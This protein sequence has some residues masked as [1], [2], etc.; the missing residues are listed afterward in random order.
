MTSTSIVPADKITEPTPPA[1]T[2]TSMLQHKIA[3]QTWNIASEDVITNTQHLDPEARLL[4][5]WIFEWAHLSRP[6]KTLQ[7]AAEAAG[8]DRTT[9]YRVLSG[10]YKRDGKQ[11]IIPA[12]LL[13]GLANLKRLEDAR[14][15]QGKVPFVLTKTAERIWG[16]ADRCL[17]RNCIGF[18]WG[19]SQYGKTTALKEYQRTHNHGQTK[20]IC[21]APG[22][23]A[24]DLLRAIAT[25]CGI[26]PKASIAELRDRIIAALDHNHLVIVDEVHQAAATYKRQSKITSIELLRWIHDQT[27]CGMLLCGTN[28]WRD[29][30]ERDS[31]SKLL[32]QVARRGALKLQ[33][34]TKIPQADLNQIFAAFELPAPEGEAAKIMRQIADRMGL[35]VVT[36]TLAFG[37]RQGKKQGREFPT[38]DDVVEAAEILESLE[39]GNI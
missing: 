2:G 34:P 11:D 13:S 26:S 16:I 20:Y 22:G 24:Q 18:L 33:L 17:E 21:L 19:D 35:K 4:L 23:G 6:A 15:D 12:K 1:I 37:Q 31:D 36:E 27:K 39:N 3:K 30:I 7:E 5:R 29:M 9:L 25:A 32:E 38:W 8:V 10:K 28:I 14:R